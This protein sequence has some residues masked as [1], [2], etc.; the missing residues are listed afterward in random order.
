MLKEKLTGADHQATGHSGAGRGL[1]PG[2]NK[3][4]AITE[5]RAADDADDVARAWDLREVIERE[6]AGTES[7]GTLSAAVVGAMRENGLFWISVPRALG[8]GGKGIV[9]GM[10]AGGAGAFADGSTGWSLMANQGATVT[11]AAYLGDQAIEAMFGDGNLPIVAG[12]FGAAGECRPREGGYA[13]GGTLT[14]FIS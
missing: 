6:A 13:E 7:G 1:T 14:F 12:M 11:A 8:G 5:S 10:S 4:S 2:I 3:N 9:E